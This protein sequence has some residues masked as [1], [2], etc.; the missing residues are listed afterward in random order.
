MNNRIKIYKNFG[1]LSEEK[2]AVYTY[3]G[4][5]PLAK[6]SEVLYAKIPDTWE[7]SENYAGETLLVS[8]WGNTYLVNDVLSGDKQPYFEAYDTD[9]VVRKYPLKIW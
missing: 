6:A 3:G 1:V 2:K 4:S 5:H 7:F 8:P 9:K